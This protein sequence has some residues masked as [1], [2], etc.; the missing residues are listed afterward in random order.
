MKTLCFMF[1]AILLVMSSQLHPVDCRPL[2]LGP[3]TAN[4]A[5]TALPKADEIEVAA[6]LRSTTPR[7]SFRGL[8]AIFATGPSRRGPGH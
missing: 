7:L 2:L 4:S 1:V 8:S 6:G 3:E 5:T